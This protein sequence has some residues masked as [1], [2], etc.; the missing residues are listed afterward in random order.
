MSLLVGK[1]YVIYI[2]D[3]YMWYFSIQLHGRERTL[4]FLN[5]VLLWADISSANDWS[6]SF[7][8]PKH[9]N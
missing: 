4:I 7:P 2:I 8:E 9:A 5:N 3:I 1:G 6:D